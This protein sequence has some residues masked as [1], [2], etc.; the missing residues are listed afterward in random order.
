MRLSQVIELTSGKIRYKVEDYP[1]LQKD[2][3]GDTVLTTHKMSIPTYIHH[4]I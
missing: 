2:V 4:S 1:R 3:Y